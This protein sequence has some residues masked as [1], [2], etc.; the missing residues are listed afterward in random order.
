MCFIVL[1]LFTLPLRADDREI[2]RNSFLR[3]RDMYRSGAA[4]EAES[5]LRQAVTFLPGYSETNF[6][7]GI[8]LCRRQAA[9]A[10]GV[11][12]IERAVK[13]DSW[14]DTSPLEARAVLAG[15][16]LRTKRFRESLALLNS[17]QTSDVYSSEHARDRALAAYGA[18][19]VKGADA[20]F[21]SALNEFPED[22]R[23]ALS[24]IQTLIRRGLL[25]RARTIVERGER[26]FPDEP[27]FL[28]Y[29]IALDRTA[30]SRKSDFDLYRQKGGRDPAVA[31]YLLDADNATF[32]AALDFFFNQKGDESV[33]LVE[34]LLKGLLRNRPRRMEAIR[35]IGPLEGEKTVDADG[36]GYYEEKYSFKGNELETVVIDKNQDGM[37]E[38]EIEFKKKSPAS[39]TVLR[40]A[41][42]ATRFFY[43]GYPR[44]S[45]AEV[46]TR[47]GSDEYELIPDALRFAPIGVLPVPA[48]FKLR[49]SWPTSV[50][51][52][53]VSKIARASYSLTTDPAD[54]RLPVRKWD[55]YAGRKTVLHE[56]T[57]RIGRFDRVVSYDAKGLP[58]RGRID[59]D[60][61]GFY[62]I[63][64]TYVRG[65]LT[66]IA[67][68]ENK[69]GR[70][71][72]W[73]DAAGSTLEWDLNGDGT[74][75]VI[76][77]RGPDGRIVADYSRLL[78]RNK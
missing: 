69:D 27:G 52:P 73:Q 54:S 64:E 66:R 78:R 3:A 53:A 13:L 55:L 57:Y 32:T 61:D 2:A 39:I 31:L 71:D 67:Y 7:I 72:Y 42:G 12:L 15:V 22:R 47:E 26:E 29:K 56:D 62:E 76:G 48:D 25:S 20:I 36:D 49:V 59:L 11:S 50:V 33:L 46:T 4:A 17:L 28:L 60:G 65:T 24:Y 44:L 14:T 16:Y 1:F 45:R 40:P 77:R 21:T 19:D 9:T 68:D 37:P 51:S 5:L 23:I 34:S 10:E 58:V 30:S 8:I 43:N 74:P 63:T 38:A 75:D 35:R 6:L 18:D 70:P 41:G